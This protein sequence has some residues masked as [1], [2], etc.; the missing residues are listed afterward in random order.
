M[1]KER[2]QKLSHSARI[3]VMMSLMPLPGWGLGNMAIFVLE[4]IFGQPSGFS[5]MNFIIVPAFLTVI[6]LIAT[7]SQV[8]KI[9]KIPAGRMTLILTA[10][11]G[12]W[13]E[14][15]A[16]QIHEDYNGYLILFLF[17]FGLLFL[18]VSAGFVVTLLF[19]SA[20]VLMVLAL[21]YFLKIPWGTD[22]ELFIFLFSLYALSTAIHNEITRR[23]YLQLKREQKKTSH[24]FKQLNKVFYPH[25]LRMMEQG[26]ELEKTMPCGSGKG[27]AIF[28]DIMASSKVEHE[29]AQT[30]F[31]E[32]FG[33]CSELM[34]SQYDADRMECNAFRINEMGDGFLCSIGYPF[35]APDGRSNAEVALELSYRFIEIF[36]QNMRTLD[37]TSPIHC[38]IGIAS[39]ELESFY[40]TYRPIEYHM[41]GRAVILATRYEEVRKILAQTMEITGS[42]IILQ[43]HVYRSLPAEVRKDFQ[44]LDLQE[45]DLKVR[46]DPSA[47]RLFYRMLNILEP[48]VPAAEDRQAS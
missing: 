48:N 16:V 24:S 5:L 12:V 32:A 11:H 25:Q 40:T 46:D 39:G 47:T 35:Q 9:L 43:S 36:E 31:R 27:C 15:A 20:N 37:Y 44:E 26:I 7:F 17:S 1:I 22:E 29:R 21:I 38:S 13:S 45:H 2:Y 6:G 3:G 14:Y 42:M 18:K 8:Y 33:R 23:N 28:F 30:L 10:M 34:M 4:R 19:S 41:Y